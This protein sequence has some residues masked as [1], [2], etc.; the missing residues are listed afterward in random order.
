MNG[1]LIRHHVFSCE[2]VKRW[3]R[4]HDLAWC[5]QTQGEL[6][7]K[8]P[9]KTA[10]VRQLSEPDL[11]LP[12]RVRL[13][14]CCVLLLASAAGCAQQASSIDE[15]KALKVAFIYNFALYTEW[16]IPLPDGVRLCVLG[17]DDLGPA[18]DAVGSRQI[19]GKPV[20]LQRL[21]AGASGADCH[22]IYIADAKSARVARELRQKPILSVTDAAGVEFAMV[23][24][25]RDKNRLVFDIDNSSARAAGL[26]LSSKLLHL[27]R[28]VH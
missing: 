8:R 21:E 2:T 19:N 10:L 15:E 6:I 22:V 1:I 23:T 12:W 27:A 16:P 20:T 3:S 18:L 4:T 11:R 26:A 7:L 14:T 13:A 28:S 5:A 17:H 25:A 24:L 9:I